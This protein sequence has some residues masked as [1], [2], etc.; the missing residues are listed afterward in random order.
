MGS[1]LLRFTASRRSVLAGLGAVAAAP[2]T[3]IGASPAAQ[4]TA[5]APEPASKPECL[6]DLVAMGVVTR[7]DFMAG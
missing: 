4:A 5:T 6:A 7:G 1:P 3:L 2:L